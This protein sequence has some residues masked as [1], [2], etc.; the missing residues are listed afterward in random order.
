MYVQM[1]E[2]RHIC[3]VCNTSLSTTRSQG[4]ERS[5]HVLL[6][7]ENWNATKQ[8]A[9]NFLICSTGFGR[10]LEGT[11]ADKTKCP[12]CCLCQCK[13]S[14]G[15]MDSWV[16]KHERLNVFESGLISSPGVTISEVILQTS[17]SCLN[18]LFFFNMNL[19][20]PCNRL[21]YFTAAFTPLL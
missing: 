13:S 20:Q 3:S 21:L 19:N 9:P 18:V 12:R 11:V 6:W 7:K 17:T 10:Q 2:W 5:D 15:W 8:N 14:T 4:A 16:T 1:S